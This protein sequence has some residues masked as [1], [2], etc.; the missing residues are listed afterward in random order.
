MLTVSWWLHAV[1]EGKQARSRCNTALPLHAVMLNPRYGVLIINWTLVYNICLIN[2]TSALGSQTCWPQMMDW[3]WYLR[4]DYGGGSTFSV[5]WGPISR[6]Q[7][8]QN[9]SRAW[10]AARNTF[11]IRHKWE[12]SRCLSHNPISHLL[13]GPGVWSPLL[14]TSPRTWVW[15]AAAGGGSSSAV[16]PPPSDAPAQPQAAL[17]PHRV[18]FPFSPTSSHLFMHPFPS[19]PEGLSRGSSSS[20]YAFLLLSFQMCC[21]GCL[22]GVF[23][24]RDWIWFAL[25]CLDNYS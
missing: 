18:Y 5:H 15:R 19:A 17:G 10:C 4:L 3:L 21:L 11:T 22:A 8:Q 2:S 14:T 25:P 6:V 1:S 23:K 20:R 12:E 16:P 24:V 7:G 13:E 9:N